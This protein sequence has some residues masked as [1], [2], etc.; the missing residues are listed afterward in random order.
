M[1]EAAIRV[2]TARAPAISG[3]REKVKVKASSGLVGASL[4]SS[5][6]ELQGG[7]VFGL[8]CNF[9]EIERLDYDKMRRHIEPIFNSGRIAK[10]WR[11]KR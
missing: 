10:K 8:A 9:R 6:C 2:A 11:L 3:R 7:S 1:G 4:A 5:A